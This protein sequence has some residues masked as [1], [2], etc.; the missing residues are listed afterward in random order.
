VVAVSAGIASASAPRS[1]SARSTSRSVMMPV[2]SGRGA[3]VAAAP[4]GRTNSEE[5]RSLAMRE[6]AVA[7]VVSAVMNFGALITSLARFR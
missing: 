4:R 7:I 3:A 6:M 1:A 5:I 2:S